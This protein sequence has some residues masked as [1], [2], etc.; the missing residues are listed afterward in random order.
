MLAVVLALQ[1]G[2]FPVT[3]FA[4]DPVLCGLFGTCAP[5]TG[6]GGLLGLP[7]G[8][9]IVRTFNPSGITS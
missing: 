6:T 5:T 3:V 9:L 1:V 7:N 2:G 8:T 4:Q